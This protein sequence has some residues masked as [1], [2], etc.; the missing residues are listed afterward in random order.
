M[1]RWFL[2]GMLSLCPLQGEVREAYGVIKP[3]KNLPGMGM[4][5]LRE[6]EGLEVEGYYSD[7]D[8][9]APLVVSVWSVETQESSFPCVGAHS[10]DTLTGS[11][12]RPGKLLAHLGQLVPNQEGYSELSIK[13]DHLNL[14]ALNDPRLCLL[15]YPKDQ[16]E[17]VISKN[18]IEQNYSMIELRWIED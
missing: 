16:K 7:I 14:N 17:K 13:L 1:K 15:I 8:P 4:I 9:S 18:L 5:H 6:K 10:Q 3:T 11:I 2:L 12:A